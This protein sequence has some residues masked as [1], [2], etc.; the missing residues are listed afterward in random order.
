MKFSK[1]KVSLLSLVIVLLI[2]CQSDYTKTVKKELSSGKENNA[3]FHGLEFGQTQNEFFEICWN[4]NKQGLATH[5]GNN[6]NVKMFLHPQDSTKTT[7]TIEMLFYPKF[8]PN[9]KIIAMNVKFSYTA[10]SLWNKDLES[11][12]LLPVIKDSLMAWYPGNDFMKVKDLLV[13][14]DGN[15]QIQLNIESDKDVAVLIEDLAYKY[16]NLKNKK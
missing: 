10:W 6:Q 11:D 2:A 9:N 13:K 4:L 15:R 8:S 5:G 7:E 12:D 14:V 16:N 1:S 3:I